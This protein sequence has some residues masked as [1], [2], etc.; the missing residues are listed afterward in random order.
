M[1]HIQ[2]ARTF[3]EN[4]IKNFPTA[5]K[6]ESGNKSGRKQKGANL[7]I[8]KDELSLVAGIIDLIKYIKRSG[9]VCLLGNIGKNSLIFVCGNRCGQFHFVRIRAVCYGDIFFI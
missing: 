1:I 6:R 2:N 5:F 8:Q 7:L 4:N 9:P 3:F